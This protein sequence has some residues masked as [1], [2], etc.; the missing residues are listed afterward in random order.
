MNE[1]ELEESMKLNIVNATYAELGEADR[2]QYVVDNAI[3]V[4]KSYAKQSLE[5]VVKEVTAKGG[6]WESGLPHSVKRAID[7]EIGRL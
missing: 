6:P 4:A 7:L 5:R 3:I 1:K 2:V